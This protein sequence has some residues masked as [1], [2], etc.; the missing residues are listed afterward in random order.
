MIYM[1]GLDQLVLDLE[2]L[3]EMPDNVV[4]GMLEAGGEI[5]AEGQRQQLE[6]MGLVDSRVLKD[7]IQVNKKRR[8]KG[9]SERSI[10][11]Y[12]HGSHHKYKARGGGTKTTSASDVGFVQEM[13]SKRNPAN[14]WMRIAN[15]KNI[16]AAVEAEYRVYNDYLK[17][18]NL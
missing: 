17:S 12:P 9:G 15:E 2:E 10:Y 6:A 7:S 14:Q 16:D 8:G 1:D 13:G 4:Y 11:I 3:E 5:I 18:K